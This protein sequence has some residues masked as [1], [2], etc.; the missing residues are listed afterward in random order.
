MLLVCPDLAEAQSLTPTYTLQEAYRMAL[1]NY[2]LIGAMRERVEQA[3]Q[4]RRGAKSLLLPAV[5]NQTILTKNFASAE[6]EFEGQTLKLLPAYDYNIAFVVSQPVFSGQRNLNLK[7]QADIGVDVAGKSYLTTAQESL[8]DVA[9]AYYLVLAI[10]ENINITQR[11]VEVTEE[12]LRTAESLFRAGES[13]ETAVLRARVAHTDAQREL[14]EARNNFQIAKDQL[15]VLT[16]IQGDYEVSRPEKPNRPDASLEE[17]IE[18]GFQN[19]PELQGLTLQREIAD[20]QIKRQKGQYFPDITVEGTFVKRRANFPSDTLSSVAVNAN[21]LLFDGFRRASE[22]AVAK[23]QMREV[24]LQRDLL[25][26]RIE[27]QVRAAYLDIETQAASVDMLTQQ[28]EFAR[29]NADST[30]KA[31]R[32]GEA[33]DLDILASNET[34]IRS[35][36]QFALATY[37]LE[38]AIYE[39]ERAIGTFVRDLIPETPGGKE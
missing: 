37:E 39:L 29:K 9:R 33:T 6:L 22:V 8:L 25:S 18:M 27:Q 20:L 35:E 23:S 14:L 3:R 10:Q 16:G 11:S 12:T 17:L 32:V 26:E 1:G 24:D 31:F 13:V 5:Y 28:V 2:Q 34:L 21:W 38:L 36:R 19:R 30:Q 15:S 7:K 4:A